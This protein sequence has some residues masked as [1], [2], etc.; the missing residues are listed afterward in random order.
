VRKDKLGQFGGH[1]AAGATRR[2]PD[3]A[4]RRGTGGQ[5]QVPSGVVT[6]AAAAERDSCADQPQVVS[7]VILG[8]QP[9]LVG[10]AG[11]CDLPQ[12]V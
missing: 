12:P 9:L 8:D 1:R 4:A 11:A 10:T 5:L 6:A 2:Q 7:V 3:L